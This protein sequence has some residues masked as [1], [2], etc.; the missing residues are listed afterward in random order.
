MTGPLAGKTVLITREKKQASTFSRCIKL[1]GGH[2][3]EVPLL[4]INCTNPIDTN[5]SMVDFKQYDW[6]FFTSAN[7]VHCF[8]NSAQREGH[9]DFS[10]VRLAAVGP[11]TDQA[12]RQYGY[13]AEFIPSVYNA[14]VMAK[15][16]LPVAGRPKRILLVQGNWSRDVLPNFFEEHAIHFDTLIAYQTSINYESRE[17]LNHVLEQKKVDFLT[18][19]SPSTLNAFVEM[20]ETANYDKSWDVCVCIGTTTEQAA[21]ANGFTHILT[22][23]EFTID[24]MLE[25][26][27]AY[28]ERMKRDG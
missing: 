4:K 19:T 13:Q 16:F 7:G 17:L 21:L 25:E 28:T 18:F 14:D 24:G 26:M 2:P 23:A 6:L 9:A 22:P 5:T 8:L 27:I 15:E 3:V 12:L 1:Q 10:N 20:A 11:K